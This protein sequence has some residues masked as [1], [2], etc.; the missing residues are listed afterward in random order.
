MQWQ[1]ELEKKKART[2]TNAHRNLPSSQPYNSFGNNN[3][4]ETW[5][6]KMDL[7][8][9]YLLILTFHDEQFS[10]QNNKIE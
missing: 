6:K 1:S 2:H 9:M 3:R 8:K 4:R 5:Q 10:T 7:K